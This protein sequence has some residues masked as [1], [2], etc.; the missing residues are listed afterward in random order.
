[1]SFFVV[2]SEGEM[3]DPAFWLVFFLAALALNLS[4]GPDLLFVLS[5]TLSGGR[6]VGVASACGVCSG[7]LVHVAADALARARRRWLICHADEALAVRVLA[8]SLSDF[9]GQTCEG[10]AN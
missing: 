5:R 3:S 8:S 4:P 10:L 9:C 6:R 2:A 7:A 1:M